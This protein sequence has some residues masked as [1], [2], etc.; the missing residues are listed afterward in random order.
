[1][2]TIPIQAIAIPDCWNGIGVLGDQSC[3][4]LAVHVHC[5]NCDVYSNAAQ[6]SLQRPVSDGYREEWAR[7]FR[8]PQ[9]AR[10]VDDRS[11]VVFRIGR[12]WLALPTKLFSSVA[13]QAPSHKLPHRSGGG[14]IGIVNIGGRL[15]PSMSLAAVLG[16]DQDDAPVQASRHIFARLLVMEWEQQA[17]ALPVADLHGIVRYASSAVQAPAATLNK[18]LTRFLTGVLAQDGMRIGCLDAAL[19]GHQLTRLLR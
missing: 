15:Y 17:F 2:N 19:I 4:K 18:G 8:Q 3:E 12:E 9:A 7:H 5:R 1:M 13:P 16:I 11:A 6:L 10:E 14:L